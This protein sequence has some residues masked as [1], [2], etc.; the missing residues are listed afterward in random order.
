MN[1]YLSIW[2][3]HL[4]TDK[5]IQLR[6]ELKTCPFVI[7][8]SER[9][10]MIIKTAS[11]IARK[12]GITPG[13]VLADGKAVLPELKVFPDKVDVEKKLLTELALWCLRFTPVV[14]IDPP[15]GLL[16]DIS[17]CAHLWGGEAPY[18]K[19]ITTQLKA[20][21]YNVKAAIADTI[22]VAWAIARFDKDNSIIHPD[23]QLP[24]LKPLPPAALR[25][26]LPILERMYNLGFHSIDNFITMPRSVLRRRFGLPLLNRID[27]ALG[28]ATELLDPIQPATAFQKRLPCLEPIRTRKGIDIAL[29]TLVEQLC[30]QLLTAGKGLRSAIFKCYRV[31]GDQQQVFVG[32]NSPVRNVVHLLK[33]FEQKTGIL[34][35]D[36][37]FELFVLEAPVTEALS[38]RQEAFWS[39]LGGCDIDATILGLLDR[40]STRMGSHTVKRYI[41]TERYLPEW[42]FTPAGSLNDQATTSWRNDR[43]RPVL[44]LPK[45]EPVKVTV[46]IPD[47]PPMMFIYKGK[48]HKIKKADGPERIEN[49]WWLEQGLVRDYYVVEN[50]EGAR[51]WLFRLGQYDEQPKKP[52]WFIH[53]FFA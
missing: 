43:P 1:R 53:G 16:L 49:E 2:L 51:Y 48:T 13:M 25:L 28:Q 20:G 12:K 23:G 31:D 7:A 42:S 35:P 41:P 27:Q 33:L 50:E 52:A 8:T 15:E 44:L 32:T 39:T 38:A 34:M 17:G 10:R 18:L 47:Y 3:P 37:G 9:G 11:P 4:I 19:E 22:G 40:I 24:A 36:L 21:G 46:P 30:E 45:P 29:Q 14:A 6:P 26:E 5:V